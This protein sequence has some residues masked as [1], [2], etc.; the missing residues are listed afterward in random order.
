MSKILSKEE[1]LDII[2][3]A[4]KRV[5]DPSTT[6]PYLTVFKESL[7]KA[8]QKLADLEAQNSSEKQHTAQPIIKS[9]PIPTTS[10]NNPTDPAITMKIH[11]N[12]GAQNQ[13]FVVDSSSPEQVLL[14]IEGNYQNALIVVEMPDGQKKKYLP[15]QASATLRSLIRGRLA[16]L[17]KPTQ[18]SKCFKLAVALY[19]GLCSYYQKTITQASLFQKRVG[20][21]IKKAFSQVKDAWENQQNSATQGR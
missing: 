16:T 19:G 2:A 13:T 6:E 8:K 4:Q 17:K 20:A 1:L 15:G 3:T 18:H 5:D 9:S 10:K 7:E 11:Q 12:G 21:K 14:K